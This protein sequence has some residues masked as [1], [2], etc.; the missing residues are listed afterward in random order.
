MR[1]VGCRDAGVRL[2]WF[3]GSNAPGTARFHSR[4]RRESERGVLAWV[5]RLAHRGTVLGAMSF[6]PYVL[7]RAGL[8]D[9]RRCA[10]HWEMHRVL[11]EEF[12]NVQVT[13]SV[14]EIDGDR[15]TCAGG[16]SSLGLSLALIAR[17]HGPVLAARIADQYMHE[18]VR[19]QP[20]QSPG[21]SVRF[22]GEE[23]T[24]PI[25]VYA[26]V[27]RPLPNDLNEGVLERPLFAVADAIPSPRAV[28][29]AQPCATRPGELTMALEACLLRCYRDSIGAMS[30][31]SS[32]AETERF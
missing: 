12:P 6:G 1:K 14:L 8:L 10:A 11:R 2:R 29:F 24:R 7:A 5:R 23:A 3:P 25:R 28:F 22:S 20:L 18:R 4:P 31:E 13:N 32:K 26:G 15:H 27:S 30:M 16:T 9:G 19:D 17:Q 21:M